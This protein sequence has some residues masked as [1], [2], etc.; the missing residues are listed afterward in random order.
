MKNNRKALYACLILFVIA[1]LV[2]VYPIIS[3]AYTE[4]HRSQI[5]T[6]Y[7][8][9]VDK[10]DTSE[11]ENAY[12]AAEEYNTMLSNGVVQD[13]SPFSDAN[14][15]S[16][17]QQYND[18][19]NVNGDGIMAYIDIPKLDIYLPVGH[20]TEADTLEN[21]VGHVIGSSIPIGGMSTHAVLSGHSGMAS[22]KMFSDLDALT[23]GDV[24]YIHVLDRVLAYEIDQ[25]NVVLP[26]D[27]SLL[28]IVEG[29]DYVTLVT[30]TPFGVNTHRLLIR[31][32]RTEYRPEENAAMITLEPD[33][34]TNSTWMAQY[35]RSLVVGGVC[36]A[37]LTVPLAVKALKPPRKRGKHE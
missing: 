24:F 18:I 2:T 7:F 4:H 19:L 13:N 27:T 33:V 9:A 10:L 20:G 12:R 3:N 11:L 5:R 15:N 35:L 21:G 34:A 30:C 25:I 28:P 14:I 17:M 22:Q 16:A 31:G 1:I 23:E 29:K 37:A 8:S 36:L 26:T 6:Q 32:V